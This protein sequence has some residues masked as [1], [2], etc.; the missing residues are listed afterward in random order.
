MTSG[1]SASGTTIQGSQF[2]T[3]NRVS[4]FVVGTALRVGLAIAPPGTYPVPRILLFGFCTAG[5]TVTIG[6]LALI[7]DTKLVTTVDNCPPK[8][9]PPLLLDPV[10]ALGKLLDPPVPFESPCP[11]VSGGL[12]EPSQVSSMPS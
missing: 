12:I 8:L 1:Q 6:F 4:V 5:W 11:T 3:R 10:P 7:T 2:I 9:L